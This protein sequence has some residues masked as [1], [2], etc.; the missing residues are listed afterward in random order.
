MGSTAS[1]QL[2]GRLSEVPASEVI[3]RVTAQGATG[4][5]RV[6]RTNPMW[7]AFSGG[8]MLAAGVIGGEDIRSL[9]VSSGAVP[10]EVAASATRNVASNDLAALAALVDAV[11]PDALRVTVHERIVETVFQLLLP[12]TEPFIF[13]DAP[14]DQ[15]NSA[16]SFDSAEIVAAAQARVQQWTTIAETINSVELVFRPRRHLSNE[17]DH[18]TLTLKEWEVVAVLDGRRNVAQV[19]AAVGRSA[20]DVCAALHD[21][22]GAALIERAG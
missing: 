6:G 7:V 1:S 20:Y 4:M 11:G 12:S 21:L 18:V 2:A 15:L 9:V 13:A 17:L 14:A 19:I 10:A 8:R 5:L 16:L 22:L 3:R